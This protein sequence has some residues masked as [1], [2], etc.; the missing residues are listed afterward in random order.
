MAPFGLSALSSRLRG[1]G[2]AKAS[3][4]SVPPASWSRPFG[5][6]WEQPYT[7]RYA[8]NLDDGPSHGMPLGGFGAGCIGRAPDGNFNLWHL[9]G[10]EHWFGTLPDCQFSLFESGPKGS[11]AHALAVK[12]QVDASRPEAGEPLPAWDWYPA[13]TPGRS[14]GTYAAR[15]PLSWSEYEGVFDAQV[16]VQAF[17]P[18]LPG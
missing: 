8:S 14:T 1:K 16:G 2:S 3:P 10:G 13:S 9:D 4:W 15:Y 18:I 5:L 11:R 6:G 17:S 12:P 7:V